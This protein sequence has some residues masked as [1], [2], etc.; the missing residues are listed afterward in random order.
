MFL[1]LRVKIITYGT[2]GKCWWSSNSPLKTRDCHFSASCCSILQYLD[3]R[4]TQYFVVP[5]QNLPSWF[6]PSQCPGWS[7]YYYFLEELGPP[8]PPPSTPPVSFRYPEEG[9]DVNCVPTE[10]GDCFPESSSG[11]FPG[12]R[13]IATPS[14]PRRVVEALSRSAVDFRSY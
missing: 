13:R 4:S 2:F 12:S 1:K 14:P 6:L 7:I 8:I 9:S 11:S 5:R 10:P 3:L